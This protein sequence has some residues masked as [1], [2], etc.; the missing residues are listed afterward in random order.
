MSVNGIRAA[1]AEA[2]RTKLRKKARRLFATRG[3]AG[4]STEAIVASAGVTKGALYHHFGDKE[5]LFRAVVED[6]EQ[7]VAEAVATATA[8]EPDPWRCLQRACEAYL[9]TSLR[10][11]IQRILV[12]D[13]PSVLGWHEWCEVDKRYGIAM[14]D[15]TLRDTMSAGLIEDQ[16]PETVAQV[17]LGALNVAARVAGSAPD[18]R[19]ARD[20]VWGT[21]ARLLSG[22]RTSVSEQ[23]RKT[24]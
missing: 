11:D 13:A 21:I 17:L 10:A 19:S 14:F 5:G 20:E 1:Q 8:G 2:T 18:G 16:A 24:R 7:E 22:L 6:L 23:N 9:D 4:A 3:Y 12:L 15:K